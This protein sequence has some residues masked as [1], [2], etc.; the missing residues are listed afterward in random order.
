[1]GLLLGAVF[2]PHRGTSAPRLL[3]PCTRDLGIG[4]MLV[5]AAVNLWV[6]MRTS[7]AA[8]REDSPALFA[9]TSI[10]IGIGN[11][12]KTDSARVKSQTFRVVALTGAV[13]AVIRH[14]RP[15]AC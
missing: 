4:V 12:P 14:R 7:A 13:G 6:S 8:K 10:S 3:L 11:H 1:M 2:H 5:S 15:C 9:Q